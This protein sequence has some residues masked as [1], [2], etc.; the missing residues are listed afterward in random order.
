MIRPAFTRLYDFLHNFFAAPAS[1][2]PLGFFRISV[3]LLA[4]A[5]VF[6]LWPYLLQLY[7]N[8]GFVQWV[9]IEADA[10]TWYPSIGKL[11][12]ALQPYGVSSAMSVYGV[13]TLYALGLVGLLLGWHTRFCAV[14]VWLLHSLTVNSGFTSLYGVDTMLH[15]CLFYC[16]WMP[17][18]DAFSLDALRGRISSAPSFLANLSLRALQIHLCL[19][20][21]N[22]G[23]AK[24][25]GEQWRGGEAIWR[26]MMQPQFSVFDMSWLAQAPWLALLMCWSVIIVELGYALFI[27]P[28]KTRPL[29]V[30]AA[31]TLH[32]GIGFFMGLWM[33]SLMMIIMNFSAF[34]FNLLPRQR[35]PT[36]HGQQRLAWLR[37]SR[38]QAARLRGSLKSHL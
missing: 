20:Y 28:A 38:L 18:G 3:S 13:F 12:L 29:L 37:H 6:Q 22:T 2:H 31:V 16:A 4:L 27:W 21:L 32:L 36:M 33:F 26:A 19:I 8:F 5:Q 24:I 25:R 11:C 7:G 1:P 35:N 10:K 34:G 17:V 23:L 30:A 14:P 15:I 9:I